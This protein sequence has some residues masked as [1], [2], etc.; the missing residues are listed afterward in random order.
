MLTITYTAR[1]AC[2]DLAA[3]VREQRLDR[4]WTQADLAERA[5]IAFST[6][7]HFE[8]TGQIALERLVMLAHALSANDGFEAL[9]ARPHA[10]SL[11]E[12]EARQ[13][14]RRRGRRRAR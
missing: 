3:R 13:T 14:V 2:L 5:G 8:R 11:A 7:R 10:R 12:L 4:G 9:F 1:E 6:L